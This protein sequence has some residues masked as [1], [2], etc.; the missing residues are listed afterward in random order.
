MIRPEVAALMKRWF[1][2]MVALAATVAA[3][4]IVGLPDFS[5]NWLSV[6]LGAPL[7]IGGVIWLRV[8]IR[9]ARAGEAQGAGRLFVEERRVLHV[10]GFGNVQVDLDDAARIDL[11]VHG[12][13]AS[14]MVHVPDGP[15]AAL[16]LG[17]EG[18]DALY[19][20]LTG[21]PG[22]DTDALHARLARARREGKGAMD[23]VWTR[24]P[25]KGRRLPR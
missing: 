24:P 6:L 2:P 1:E 7:A 20:A 18:V 17:A 8:A 12:P 21:L 16:P 15:P 23:T 19:D 3:L 13:R 9:R 4:W 25:A 22:M 10:G 11:M 14:L 5:L